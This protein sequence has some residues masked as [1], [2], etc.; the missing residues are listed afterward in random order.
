MYNFIYKYYSNFNFKIKKILSFGF[1]FSLLISLF[2]AFILS[3]YFSTYTNPILYYVGI[4][5]FKLSII[6]LV[7]FIYFIF[8]FNKILDDIT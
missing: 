7:T 5:V 2:S 6:Y 8:A 4:S 1:V 3:T